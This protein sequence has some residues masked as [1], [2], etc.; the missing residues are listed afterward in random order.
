M[1]VEAVSHM[2][3]RRAAAHG[4]A[5]HLPLRDTAVAWNPR[6]SPLHASSPTHPRTNQDQR[7]QPDARAVCTTATPV[8]IGSSV[9]VKVTFCI[10]EF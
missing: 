6:N 2:E 1:R 5:T 9:Q 8:T 7:H 3:R 10:K 4:K